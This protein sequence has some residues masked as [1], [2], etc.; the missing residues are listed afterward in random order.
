MR[1]QRSEKDAVFS[2][3][4][5]AIH[6]RAPAN[7]PPPGNKIAREAQTQEEAGQ[8]GRLLRKSGV[9]G[10]ALARGEAELLG[11]GA[12]EEQ[13]EAKQGRLRRSFLSPLLLSRIFLYASPLF[14]VVAQDRGAFDSPLPPLRRRSG[15]SSWA[16]A[17]KKRYGL[18]PFVFT[19]VYSLFFS[20]HQS[21]SVR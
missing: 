5:A 7:P 21:V 16:E 14:I 12:R 17:T 8:S 10:R 4:A 2:R 20:L 18:V 11:E 6:S 3:C 15:P 9:V 19:G 13:T 1:Q